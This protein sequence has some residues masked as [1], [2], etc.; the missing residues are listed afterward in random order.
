MTILITGAAG[1]IGSH[2]AQQYCT[3][4]YDVIGIDN[5]NDYYSVDLKQ[6][7][8]S[9]LKHHKNFNFF[10]TDFADKA[11]LFAQTQNKKIQKII[12]L[13]AQAGVRYSL[14]NP[15]VYINSNLIGHANIL[16][17][18]RS[19]D[20][21]EHLIYASSSSVYGANTKQPFA[22]TDPVNLPVSL[23]A[24]TK[25]SNELMSQSYAHLYGIPQTGLRLFTVYGPWGRPD[26]A[27][28]LFTDAIINERPI[29]V[30]NHGD[31]ARDFTFID[32]IV[33]G[34]TGLVKTPPSKGGVNNYEGSPSPHRIYN[35]GNNQPENLMKFISCLENAIGKKAIKVFEDLQD[36]DLKET[37]ANID[38]IHALTGFTPKTQLQDGLNSFVEWFKTYHKIS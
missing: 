29:K 22:E 2:I 19:L 11:A 5:L 15:D 28:W 35:I 30:F 34:I 21:F 9:N 25:R 14:K 10:H 31:M 20:S 8:L 16:E 7:R 1:F 3:H 23:Y 18:A 27:P 37:T 36:G 32:D 6:A 13:G 38:A 24:A 26:M 33:D 12:H 17:L 4:G